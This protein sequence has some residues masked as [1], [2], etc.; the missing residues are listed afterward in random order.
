MLAYDFVPAG[1]NC[2]GVVFLVKQKRWFKH[3]HYRN[4]GSFRRFDGGRCNPSGQ[5]MGC[6]AGREGECHYLSG[7]QYLL[8]LR[9]WAKQ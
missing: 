8:G 5:D 4:G 7:G 3:M 2:Q 9:D 6:L 1:L